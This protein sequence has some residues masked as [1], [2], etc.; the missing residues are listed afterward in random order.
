[1]KLLIGIGTCLFLQSILLMSLILDILVILDLTELVKGYLK[2]FANVMG[3]TSTARQIEYGV[4]YG[5]SD[6]DRS[7]KVTI[8]FAFSLH[9]IH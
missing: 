1:M 4:D 2:K 9:T 5:E 3:K 7:S 6:K 8:W